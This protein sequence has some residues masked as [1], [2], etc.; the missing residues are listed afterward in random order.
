M[1]G[2]ET[3]IPSTQSNPTNNIVLQIV[4]GPR[5][6]VSAF[7]T[8]P[9]LEEIS[10]LLNNV[11]SHLADDLGDNQ[12]GLSSEVRPTIYVSTLPNV[13]L[14][15]VW[16]RYRFTCPITTITT[17]KDRWIV[18]VFVSSWESSFLGNSY[19][20]E[21]LL[22]QIFLRGVWRC[23]QDQ[24][25]P[26]MTQSRLMSWY[27]SYKWVKVVKWCHKNTSLWPV[28]QPEE[29]KWSRGSWIRQFLV[30]RADNPRSKSF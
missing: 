7:P 4:H 10:T 9:G 22:I 27:E 3:A 29:A 11:S 21:S 2:R 25:D 26:G 18:C 8:M 28:V 1:D 14:L 13:K 23:N 15:G 17:S 30:P 16:S 6:P 24:W 19:H 5:T 12:E 20:L